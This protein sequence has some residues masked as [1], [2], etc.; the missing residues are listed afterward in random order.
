MSRNWIA[1]AVA[2]TLAGSAW[3]APGPTQAQLDNARDSTEWLMPNYDYAEAGQ[4]YMGGSFT[5]DPVDK[6][7]GWLTAVRA[8]TG[9][10]VW[11]YHS[12]RPMLA[13][14]TATSGDMIFTGELTGD[15]LAMNARTG[16]VVYR[17]SGGGAII[18]GVISYAVDGKQYVAVVSGMAAGFW[19]GPQ[20]SMTVT[21]FALP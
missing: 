19:L 3:S 2:M 12:P 11:K 5:W 7:T 4:K 8:K 20:G 6:S 10:E 18:G 17:Y 13:A 16:N 21:V 14:V 9:R 1:V 15:F